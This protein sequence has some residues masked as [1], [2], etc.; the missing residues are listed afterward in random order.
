MDEPRKRGRKRVVLLPEG[1]YEQVVPEGRLP[2]NTVIVLGYR[3]MWCIRKEDGISR[4]VYNHRRLDGILY[5]N[6][7]SDKVRCA[8][9]FDNH[10]LWIANMEFRTV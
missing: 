7:H 6:S 9:K 5:L 1:F 3:L 8:C 2:V 4:R 10:S